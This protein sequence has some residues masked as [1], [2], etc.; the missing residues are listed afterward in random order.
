MKL[1]SSCLV[2]YFLLH[3]LPALACTGVSVVVKFI[4]GLNF[5]FLL[6]LDMAMYD[7]EFETIEK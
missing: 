3:N 6:F 7:N 4:L 2:Y 5:I 1:S